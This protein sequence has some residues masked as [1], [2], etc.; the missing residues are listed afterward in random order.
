MALVFVRRYLPTLKI[1]HSEKYTTEV[2]N[3]IMPAFE[4]VSEEVSLNDIKHTKTN[5]FY[6]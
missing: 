3:Y 4:F 2:F 1:P 5:V 6:K